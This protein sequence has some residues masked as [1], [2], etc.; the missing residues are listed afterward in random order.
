MV[1]FSIGHGRQINS[2]IGLTAMPRTLASSV[3]PALSG[4]LLGTPFTGLPLV[5]CGTLKIVYDVILLYAMQHT[6]PPE[7]RIAATGG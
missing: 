1:C 6:K 7:E 3:S 5:I 4:M 2:T